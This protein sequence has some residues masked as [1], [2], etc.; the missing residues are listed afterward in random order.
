MM[1]DYLLLVALVV[2]LGIYVMSRVRV[3]EEKIL[4]LKR[5][6]DRQLSEADV[7]HV[8]KCVREG[9]ADALE[10]RLKALEAQADEHSAR[11]SAVPPTPSK[12]EAVATSGASG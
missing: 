4:L 5:S 6:A 9:A 10:Q 11:L 7:E 8:L 12:K 1:R 3:L 2:A